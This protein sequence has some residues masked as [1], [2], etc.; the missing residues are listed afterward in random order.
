MSEGEAGASL[1]P[2]NSARRVL[3]QSHKT[4]KCIR[5]ASVC[6][7]CCSVL[8]TLPGFCLAGQTPPAALLRRP[9]VACDSPHSRGHDLVRARSFVDLARR[10]PGEHTGLFSRGFGS[11]HVRRL[12]PA[13][14]VNIFGGFERAP[15]I[16]ILALIDTGPGRVQG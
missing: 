6:P 11:S 8:P 1:R 3:A 5:A 12:P 13:A 10:F 7:N 16:I 2:T 14:A 15:V 9:A 4:L